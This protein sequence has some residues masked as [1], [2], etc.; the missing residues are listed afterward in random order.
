LHLEFGA[1]GGT[2]HGMRF[3]V[4]RHTAVKPPEDVLNLLDA[5]L[6]ARQDD[7]IFTKSGGEIDVRL[8]RDDSVRM[9]QDEREERGREAV[10]EAVGEVCERWPGLRLDW[11]AVSRAR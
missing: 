5:R 7:V 1:P 11:F 2:I 3:R 4:T 9:T 10:L 8:D 6:P